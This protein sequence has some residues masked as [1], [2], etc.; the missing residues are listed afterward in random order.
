MQLMILLSSSLYTQFDRRDHNGV[1]LGDSG[2]AQ[3]DFSYSQAHMRTRALVER[4][5]GVWKSRVQCLRKT[6]RLKAGRC[7]TAAET[8]ASSADAP[9]S[10]VAV[11]SESNTLTLAEIVA[12]ASVVPASVN[13]E[14]DGMNGHI[15]TPVL[16]ENIA[17]TGKSN[18]A[19]NEAEMQ[20]GAFF[21]AA[22]KRR[23]GRGKTTI[24]QAKEDKSETESAV[25]DID[26]DSSDSNDSGCSF[27][28]H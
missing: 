4:M 7:C 28:H 9:V 14:I 24:T 11:E 2:H 26:S 21:K 1:L 17:V 18:E 23:K 20:T 8:V 13:S 3:K 5:F 27:L 19:G 15:V 16:T 22:I 6:L 10:E 12:G 25:S